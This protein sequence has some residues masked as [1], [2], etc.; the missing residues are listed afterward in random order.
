MK[1][2]APVLVVLAVPSTALAGTVTGTIT[3]QA[4]GAALSGAE[5][6]A[7]S[8]NSK[9]WTIASTTTTNGSGAY[10][11]TVADGN[12]LIDAR[13]PDNGSNYGDRWYDVAAPTGGGYIGANADVIAVSG[14]VSGIN[15]ALEVLGGGDG[16]VL[17]PS[18]AGRAG[19]IVRMEQRT[20]PRIHHNDVTD[21]DLVGRVS[22]R[23]LPPAL[24]YQI[25]IYDPT[26]VYATRRL[27]GPYSIAAGAN[28]NLGNL[29]VANPATDPYEGNNNPSC[30]A[31]ID[32]TPLRMNP[33]QTFATSGARIGPTTANDRDWFCVTTVAGD[34]FHITATTAHTFNGAV[35]FDPWTDPILAFWS[36]AGVTKLV[37]DDDSGA[38]TFDPLVD[39]GPLGA[40]CHCISVSTFGDGDYNGT[41][42]G[43]SGDYRLEI[44]MGN[45]PPVVSIRKGSTEIPAAPTLLVINEGETLDLNLSYGDADGDA[46]AAVFTHQDNTG[47]DV[48]GGTLNLGA[49][50][51]T[52][53]WTVPD[54]AAPLG[55]FTINLRASETEFEMDKTILVSVV[56]VNDPPDLPVL[57]S[58]IGGAVVSE[59]SPTLVWS[60][61]TDPEANPLSYDVEVYAD[62][63]DGAPVQTQNVAEVAGGQTSLVAAPIA[64][65]TRVYWRVRAR[66]GFNGLSPWTGFESFLVDSANDPPETPIL[67]KPGNFELVSV[68]RPGLSVINVEDPEDDPIDFIFEVASDAE[69]ADIVWTSAAVPQNDVAATTT[70]NPTMDLAWGAEY[71]AR[72]K[73]VDARGEESGWSNVRQFHLKENVPPGA[74]TWDGGCMILT[75]DFS[76]PEGIE[77]TNVLDTEGEPITFELE[78]FDVLDDPNVAAPVLR[79]TAMQDDGAATTLIPFDAAD[80][81]N[82][83]YIY[84]VRAFDGTDYSD[85]IECQLI[86][87]LPGAGSGGCCQT[88]TT[89]GGELAL[90]LLVLAAVLRRRRR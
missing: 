67:T 83:H 62:D 71:F 64:E 80:L 77:V 89:G 22:F 10:S 85:W 14:T 33:P 79:V 15:L 47:T 54:D 72:A 70:T 17:Q 23:G 38:G 26:G 43:S 84:R 52:Y 41:G 81:P 60:N 48:V 2:L 32:A 53:S 1:L 45:R 31:P 78:F 39:T 16:M 59:A 37:E 20:D 58:P 69:F 68:R 87:D 21:N 73:A 27:T 90:G 88:G 24:D 3:A 44:T 13:G 18:G 4:G 35:R 42:A 6:R 56:G 74:P 51:G 66:D 29:T 82:G 12:Y 50:S 28:A 86:L 40:G 63:T 65:N 61:A 57:V 46:V 36:G 7:W 75:Y 30:A 49:T 8:Q 76:A 19:A 34:R 11:I 5:V 9:G 25:Q 55:P